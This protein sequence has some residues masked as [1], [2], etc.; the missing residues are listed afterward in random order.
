MSSITM[1]L[2]VVAA[3]QDRSFW[4][5]S[6]GADPVTAPLTGEQQCDIAIVGGGYAGLWTALRIREQEPNAR[7]TIT[8]ADFLR[9]GRIRA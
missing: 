1:R 2:P 8:E 9:F 5:Q 6:I 7:I 3:K 4:L